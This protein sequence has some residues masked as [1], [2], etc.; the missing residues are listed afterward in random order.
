M[1]VAF[2]VVP[3]LPLEDG[4]HA[5]RFL[6]NRCWFNESMTTDGVK[7]LKGYR[8]EFDEERGVF[9]KAPLHNGASHYA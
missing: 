1:G 2:K 8:R 3:S 7:A 9:I 6:L 4:I 5:V